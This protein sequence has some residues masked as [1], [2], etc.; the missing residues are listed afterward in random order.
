MKNYYC[1]IGFN[2][3]FQQ[4]FS[5]ITTVSGCDRVGSSVLTFIVLP[6]CNIMPQTLDMIPHPVTLSG[7]WV[8]QSYPVNVSAKR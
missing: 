1:C 2:R 4:F 7:H 5:H 3:R 6:H 8:G